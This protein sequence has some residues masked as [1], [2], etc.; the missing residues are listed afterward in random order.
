MKQTLCKRFLI[1]FL[2]LCFLALTS[3]AQ[4][5]T[6]KT[7]AT[8]PAKT[9]VATPAKSPVK[10]PA[11]TTATVPAKTTITSPAKTV[12]NPPTKPVVNIPAKPVDSS[13]KG[14]YEDLLKYSWMQKGY[15]V[16]N[17]ARLST[18]WE[19]VNDSLNSSKRQLA[20]AKQKLEQQAKQ[21]NELK[22][23]GDTSN[24]IRGESTAIVD[25]I[26]ILGMPVDVVTYN[27][28][29]WGAI[30]VLALGL[31]GVLFTTTKNSHDARHHKQLYEEI[32]S[33]YNIYKTKA[34][35]KELKL[36][37]ELQTERNNLEELLAKKEQDPS[38]KK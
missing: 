3:N 32:S 36:A 5:S 22:N 12:V 33:E 24:A 25:Q 7:A 19:S 17:P 26:S 4:D 11:K 21:I 1:L 15:K 30:I 37:R 14:Q 13:L 20:A 29:V 34:K 9:P 27:W 23:A 6:K 8:Q 31:G 10:S 35:E 18:L 16:I 28:I 38:R 2:N